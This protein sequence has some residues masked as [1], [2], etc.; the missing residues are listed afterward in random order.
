MATGIPIMTV[1]LTLPRD[2]ALFQRDHNRFMRAAMTAAAEYHWRQHMPR[3]FQ[4][5]AAA[6]YGY[7]PRSKKYNDRKIKI[8]GHQID[9]VLSGRSRREVTSKRTITATPKGA[10]LKM[11]L[12]IKGG[13]GNLLDQAAAARLF[14]AGKRQQKGF[15][16]RQVNS[17]KSIIAR[18]KE[19]EAIS[20]DEIRA[21]SRVIHDE[22]HRQATAP[23]TKRR[24]RF[25]SH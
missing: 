18:V 5:F 2:P 25:R 23:D 7:V 24:I 1:E 9:N 19:L 8:V 22:Y 15:T 20:A 21:N 16:A 12:P 13:T 4:K 17:Q 6:K 10:R 3:H 14:A 11:V